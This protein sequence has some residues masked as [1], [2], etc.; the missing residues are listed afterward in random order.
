MDDFVT[1][2]KQNII[3]RLQLADRRPED[4]EEGD[5][6]FGTG[7]GLDSIDAVELVVMLEKQYG[8]RLT[9]LQEAKAAF[10]T[11]GTLA[12]FIIDRRPGSGAAGAK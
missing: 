8:I 5:A 11:V 9:D 6:L 10:E 1:T 2:L 3:N 12:K 7:L 4:I